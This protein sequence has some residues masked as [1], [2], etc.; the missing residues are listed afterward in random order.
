MPLTISKLNEIRKP[1]VVTFEGETVNLTYRPW[2][3]TPDLERDVMTLFDKR[4]LG[5][6]GAG[7]VAALVTDWDV[8]AEDEGKPVAL[9]PDVLQTLPSRFLWAVVDAIREDMEGK[10]ESEK[11]KSSFTD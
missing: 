9:A 11:P 3:Y 4:L 5:G 6:A 2:A 10:P 1:L 7:Y 8:L